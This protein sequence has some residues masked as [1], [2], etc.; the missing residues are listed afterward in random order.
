MGKFENSIKE[1]SNNQWG[2]VIFSSGVL[3]TSKKQRFAIVVNRVVWYAVRLALEIDERCNEIEVYKIS[4]HLTEAMAME[5]KESIVRNLSSSPPQFEKCDIKV[6]RLGSTIYS[7]IYYAGCYLKMPMGVYESPD[8]YLKKG[9]HVMVARRISNFNIFHHA[10]IYVGN[11]KIIHITNQNDDGSFKSNSAVHKTSFSEFYKTKDTEILVW[12]NFFKLKKPEEICGTAESLIGKRQGE[13]N[14]VL[15]NCQHFSCYCQM[16]I[17][18]APEAH[19]PRNW[20][21]TVSEYVVAAPLSVIYGGT[22]LGT[23]L[24]MNE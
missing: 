15:K 4:E 5:K 19:F 16:G 22:H 18:F 10:G 1:L 8:R 20:L 7:S 6:P 9:D 12:C 3:Y 21:T 14:F 2:T 24:Y 11:E 23:T 13:Y 17:E